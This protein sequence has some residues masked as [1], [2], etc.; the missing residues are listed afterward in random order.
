MLKILCDSP[1]MGVDGEKASQPVTV[2]EALH[3]L[4][5]LKDR[6]RN[7]R[8]PSYKIFKDTLDYTERFSKVK[9]KAQIEELR[10]R[11]DALGFTSEEIAILGSLL[12]QSVDEAK[13]C[14]PSIAHLDHKIIE[15]AVERF[16]GYV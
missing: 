12:P 4:L 7:T 15:I 6:F 1:R 13:L 3:L 14:L 9:D 5:P 11:M 16:Q 10:Q 2:S 8:L